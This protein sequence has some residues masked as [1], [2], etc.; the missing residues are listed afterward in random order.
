MKLKSLVLSAMAG[1]MLFAAAGCGSDTASTTGG[2]KPFEGKKLVMY[3]SFH[4]DT[5]KGL[6]DQF[7]KDTGADVSFIRLPTGE[8]MARMMAE[9]DSPKADVWLG[10]TAD[11]HEKMKMEGIL[12]PY[13]SP[14][15]KLIPAEY[16]DPDH[17]WH[18][19]YLEALAIGYNEKRFQ[20]EFAPK[21]IKPPT[22]LEDLLN[23]A[24]KGEIIAPDP[25]K[26]GTGLTFLASV[27]QADGDAAWDYLYKFKDQVA[28]FTPSGYTPA[29][30][31]STG[32]YLIAVNFVEDQRVASQKGSKII[33]TVYKNA[34]WNIVPVS[35]IKNGNDDNK[36]ADAFIDYVLTKQAGQIIVDTTQSISTNPEVPVPAG[37]QALK[38][39]PLFKGFSFI[40]AADMKKELTQKFFGN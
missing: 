13:A 31:C 22:T 15:D 27:V 6:A 24:F 40:K 10:G 18:G 33:S 3:V 21:G 2:E 35:K 5:A 37:S 23:P 11:A 28:Q 17:Y 12:T 14:N 34:G 38:D 1:I 29:Q 39:L 36:V 4:E 30:K 16:Q 32:E 25:R 20:E 7:K 26:S 8:A 19:L 9:K